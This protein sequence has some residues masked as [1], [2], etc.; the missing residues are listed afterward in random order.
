VRS[1]DIQAIGELAGEALAAGGGLIKE[2]HEGIAS[3]PFE[4]LGPPAAPV[5]VIHD[6]IAHSVYGGVQSALRA[7]SRATA[8]VLALEA[9]DDGPAL[10]AMPAGSV[11]LGALNGVYGNH[12]VQRANRLALGMEIRRNGEAVP[13]TPA[14]LARAFPDASPRIAVFVHGLCETDD[15]WRKL[16]RRGDRERRPTYGDRLR[17]ELGFAPV[18]LRYN[19]GLHISE[20][21]RLLARTLDDLVAGWPCRIEE[22]VLVGH[23][24]GGLVS[25]SACHYAE[26]DGRRWAHAVRHVF[27]LGTPHLG[28]DLEK[29]ANFLGWALGRLPE[30]RALGSFVNA[31]SVGIKDL[32]FGSCIEEDWRD[33]D[34]DEFLRDRCQEVPFL[35]HANYYFI[36]A[37]V[38]EGPV[39]TLL[40]DL[41]VRIAS[42]SGRGRGSGRRIPFEVDNGLELTGITH[43]DLLDH[44]AVYEQLR[45]WILRPRPVRSARSTR[46]TFPLR[47]ARALGSSPVDTN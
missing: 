4:V 39:G 37:A 26:R 10:A 9:G 22:V 3:R 16:L 35:A 21:G 25:R 12:L 43:F 45:S 40:G 47:S 41:L 29:G 17:D 28:A 2:M 7:A 6:E 24:M 31:R 34:P 44:P 8:A 42:A 46:F 5:R 19:T 11:A 27:C 36:A 20:N 23:S 14:G 38:S 18:Y 30:T 15:S 33:C 1:T 13:V 32:R